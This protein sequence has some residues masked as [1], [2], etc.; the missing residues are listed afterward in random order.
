MLTL[1]ITAALVAAPQAAKPATN[2]KCPVAGDKVTP[3]KSPTVAVRGQDYYIC[4]EGCRAK[5]EKNPD[6][7]LLP[8]GTP[9]NAK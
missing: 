7:Y 2:L 6:K 3:G 8:D 9:R 4:C 1:F 5:L